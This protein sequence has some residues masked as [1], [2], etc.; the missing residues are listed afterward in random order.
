MSSSKAVVEK[1]THINVFN[2]L[3]LV[4]QFVVVMMFL[5]VYIYVIQKKQGIGHS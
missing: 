3:W 2:P 5:M 1:T 4:A